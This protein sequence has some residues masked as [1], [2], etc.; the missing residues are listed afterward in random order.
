MEKTAQKYL[1]TEPWGITERGFHANRSLVSESLF[2]L[3]NEY[4]GVR[5]YFEEGISLP[6]LRGSYFNGIYDFAKNETPNAY[7]GIVK[8]THFMVNAMDY[9]KVTVTADGSKL[10]LATAKVTDFVRH[11]D[12]KTGE[13]SREFVWHLNNKSI[14]VSFRRFLAMGDCHRAYQR[15][16]IAADEPTELVLGLFLDGNMIQWGHDCYFTNLL[17]KH[18]SSVAGVISQTLTTHQKVASFMA[19][20]TPFK[21]RYEELPMGVGFVYYISLKPKQVAVFE[22]DVVN[23][24]ERDGLQVKWPALAAEA[25]SELKEASAIGYDMA[26][27]AN[28]RY[29]SK[30]WD[31]NDIQIGGAPDDQQG[32]RFDIFQLEQTYHGYDP[33]DNIGAKG[34]TG[35]AYSGH[36]FWDSETYCLQYYLF[37]N[38][39][40]AKDLLMFRY[41]GLEEAKKRALMLDCR[42]A[43]YPIATLNGMEGCDL[44]QHASLQFQPSTGVVYGLYHYERVTGDHDFILD[45]GLE[46]VLEISRFLLD[47]GQWDG[48]HRHFG[49]YGV[50]G[51]DEFKMMVNNNTYTNYMAKKTF[52]YARELIERYKDD[53]RVTKTLEKT[54]FDDTTLT[55]MKVAEDNMLILYNPKTGLFEEN[56]GFYNLPHIDIA[57]IPVNDF[58]LYAHWT[59]DR[60]YRGD[61]IKQP[62]VL[63]FLFLHS[64]EFTK[65]QIKANYEYYEPRCIHESSLSPSIHSIL[66]TELGKDKEALS[67]FDFATRMDLDDYNRNTGEGLHLTSIA[68]AWMNIVYGFGGL[69]SDGPLLT[70]NPKLPPMWRRFSFR[71]YYQG[72]ELFIKVGP[73]GFTVKNLNHSPV[74]VSIGG[75][76]IRITRSFNK[77]DKR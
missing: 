37:N 55:E 31:H 15:I 5:G 48:S 29:W 11:L 50:M 71:L 65:R 13:L 20:N 69:R 68:A 8:R 49:Y 63:M 59:Y 21:G 33:Y 34:L 43:C 9:F 30:V 3:A 54:H 7:R 58:P 72:A 1:E 62:D 61:M 51:P 25:C 23:L 73:R 47:R 56:E 60:I 2:S 52:Q 74:T 70:L 24:A 75:R 57:K 36:S 22:R 44:W 14:N 17:K 45:Y 42:G 40:A 6:S 32:I 26:L 53:P 27:K 66:A 28:R 18:E 35:E 41:H 19:V 64:S 16:E 46:M 77:K 76:K 12:F 10:D 4:A 38:P 67:F 39:A